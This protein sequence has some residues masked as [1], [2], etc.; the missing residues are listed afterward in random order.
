MA[1][2][3]D[4]LKWRGDIDFSKSP[5]NEIDLLI[6]A[7]LS[8]MPFDRIEMKRKDTIGAIAEKMADVD[9]KY[10]VSSGDD[11]FIREVG[12]SER[13]KG[14]IVTDFEKNYDKKL[15]LQFG[16]I[17][18]HLPNRI[19]YVSFTGTTQELFGWKED[20]NMSFMEKVPCQEEARK[21]INKIANKYHGKMYVGGHSKG[22]NLAIYA[23]AFAKPEYQKRI[24]SVLNYDGPGFMEHIINTTEYTKILSKIITY[25]PQDSVVGRLMT[26]REKV[27]IVESNQKGLMQHEVVTW[28][29]L[30]TKINRLQSN[31]KES[32]MINETLTHWLESTTEEQRKVFFDCIFN[33]IEDSNFETINDLLK[34]WY[35][36]I[37]AITGNYKKLSDE[38]RKVVNEMI[39]LFA[40]SFAERRNEKIRKAIN[41]Y[42]EDKPKVKLIDTNLGKDLKP[43]FI[44]KTKFSNNKMNMPRMKK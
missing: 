1:N 18:I 5:V 39:M 41:Q 36:K 19:L 11:D 31:T 40:K 42:L 7:R 32:E 12:N 4:Y 8:Y 43:L 6:L 9:K 33:I 30:G 22:G 27:E 3:I 28:Q 37:D 38:D 29:V 10:Y 21:Y 24:I 20:F 13:F 25:I 14:L 23:S 16:A 17:T 15:E 26:H 44:K 35:K 34:N 2:A